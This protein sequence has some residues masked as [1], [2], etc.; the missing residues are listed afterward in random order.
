MRG[1]PL[2]YFT[3]EKDPE[4]PQIDPRIQTQYSVSAKKE[5]TMKKII[6][7]YTGNKAL[8]W[9]ICT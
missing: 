6:K 4:S 3:Q 1:S 7:K 2:S 9:Y 8:S 5:Q